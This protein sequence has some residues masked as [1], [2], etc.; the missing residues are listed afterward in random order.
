M[1]ARPY[2]WYAERTKMRCDAVDRIFYDAIRIGQIKVV[3]PSH[4]FLRVCQFCNL[5]NFLD[6]YLYG[7]NTG[8]YVGKGKMILKYSALF[9]IIYTFIITT[10]SASFR[11]KNKSL[12]KEEQLQAR[13]GNQN[14]YPL[15]ELFFINVVVDPFP[16]H[17]PDNYKRQ[18]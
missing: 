18:E 10:K 13:N 4:D 2:I 12:R 7:N 14:K 1:R 11:L 5:I 6:A 17:P 16:Q 9:P 15:L 8:K 3:G